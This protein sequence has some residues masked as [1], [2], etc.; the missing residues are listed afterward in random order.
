[1]VT[2]GICSLFSF[3]PYFPL[4]WISVSQKESF[5]CS[6]PAS[7]GLQHVHVHAR[8]HTL[9]TPTTPGQDGRVAFDRHCKGKLTKQQRSE[10]YYVTSEEQN[11][12]RS[13]MTTSKFTQ[14]QTNRIPWNLRVYDLS[15]GGA[16]K[17]RGS[18]NLS[19]HPDRTRT[20]GTNLRRRQWDNMAFAQG[21]PNMPP[22]CFL[23]MGWHFKSNNSA[24]N[25]PSPPPN[26]TEKKE[27]ICRKNWGFFCML[28]Q[29]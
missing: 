1:M 16:L 22:A 8:I 12:K 4:L 5:L 25:S 7:Q 17:M 14:F 15:W 21:C 11:T 2:L 18:M 6:I 24:P 10:S 27:F 26:F 28:I 3:V 13:V 9:H 19:D 20:Y 29:T 23:G